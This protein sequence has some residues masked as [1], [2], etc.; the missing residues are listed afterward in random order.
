MSFR[1]RKRLRLFPGAWVNLSKRGA[2][3]S[4]GRRRL[5]P[6]IGRKGVRESIGL[7]G[8]TPGRISPVITSPILLTVHCS[9][10]PCD[11]STIKQ[12]DFEMLYTAGRS[13]LS[14]SN[15]SNR[16]PRKLTGLTSLQFL[17]LTG[18]GQLSGDLTPLASLT[19]LQSARPFRVRAA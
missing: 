7:P 17:N 3:L 5:T 6:N 10:S 18:C 2:S 14:P 19:S 15:T 11:Q 12:Y 13:T 8:S 9:G 16:L 1:F 4:M